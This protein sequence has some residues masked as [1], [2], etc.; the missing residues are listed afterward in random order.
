MPTS[1]RRQSSANPLASSFTSQ[2]PEQGSKNPTAAF[3]P[4]TVRAHSHRSTQAKAAKFSPP[5]SP[6]LHIPASPVTLAAQ[7]SVIPTAASANIH[8]LQRLRLRPTPP[9]EVAQYLAPS[10]LYPCPLS[11]YLYHPAA[12]GPYIGIHIECTKFCN[13]LRGRRAFNNT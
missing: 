5:S 4:P 6:C 10:S 3:A 1:P 12:T 2:H 7:S 9:Q 13:G 8:S 11:L